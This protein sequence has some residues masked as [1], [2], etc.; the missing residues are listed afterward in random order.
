MPS[1]TWRNLTVTV[2]EMSR[3]QALD[4]ARDF[5]PLVGLFPA[6]DTGLLMELE[7]LCVLHSPATILGNDDGL[8]AATG[9]KTYTVDEKEL[10]ITLPITREAFD[11]LPYTLTKAW[12]IAAV[13]ANG[14]LVDD[15]KK[16]LSRITTQINASP[17]G[18]VPS[19]ES[20]TTPQTTK[21]TGE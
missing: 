11:K 2:G 9:S 1:F 21:T 8:Q 15:L 19:S 16:A 6:N 7:V 12:I 14:W 10:T 18:S 17:S 3:A 4:C 20:T 5:N 13:D